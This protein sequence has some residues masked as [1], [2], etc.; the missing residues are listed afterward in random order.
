LA[1]QVLR[2][3][4]SAPTVLNAANEIAVQA[5]LDRKIGFLEIATL[6]EETLNALDMR[7]LTS[8]DDVAEMDKQA[9]AYACASVKNRN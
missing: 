5:F 9:R 4:G 3:G 8:L 7:P 6:V 2:E 1:R